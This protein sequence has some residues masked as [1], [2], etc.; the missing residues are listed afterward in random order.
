MLCRVYQKS[1]HTQ[2][3]NHVKFES[4]IYDPDFDAFFN[5]HFRYETKII[6]FFYAKQ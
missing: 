6:E 3:M 2:K 5:F 4:Q 1:V